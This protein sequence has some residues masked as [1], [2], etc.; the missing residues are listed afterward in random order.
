MEEANLFNQQKEKQEDLTDDLVVDVSDKNE[1]LNKL[2][3]ESQKEGNESSITEVDINIKE[4]D[5]IECVD[6][7]GRIAY[8]FIVF[9][10]MPT[11]LFLYKQ[12][13]KK[14]TVRIAFKFVVEL[15]K[16]VIIEWLK[17]LFF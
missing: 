5:N 2:K 9:K 8:E 14:F 17:K 7:I 16:A 1:V 10:R 4:L 12:M 13:R 3:E 15:I 11:L 6:V